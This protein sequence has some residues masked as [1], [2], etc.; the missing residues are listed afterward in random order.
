MTQTQSPPSTAAHLLQPSQKRR[1]H[2]S[3][4][5]FRAFRNAFRS[6][7]IL[8]PAC[9][10]PSATAGRGGAGGGGDG[11]IPGAARMTGTLF[12]PRRNRI[13]L[14][15]QENSRSLPLLVLELPIATAKLLQEM[16]AGLVRIAMEC[17]KKAGG[18]AGGGGGGRRKLLEE[19]LWTV[20]CNGRRAGDLNVMG[21]L[22]AVSMGAGVLPGDGD[23]ATTGD[24]EVTYM[25]AHFDRVVGSKDS[26]T[27]YMLNPDGNG[28][29]ELSIFFVRI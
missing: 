29:P 18:S 4:K 17:E 1:P 26:E 22:H 21:L 7:P 8:S 23:G 10:I 14:A 12:G 2:R 25:R 16:A 28:G 13:S 15:I 3:T 20:Y 27:F 24:G 9:R 11:H 5:F 6:F 19:P